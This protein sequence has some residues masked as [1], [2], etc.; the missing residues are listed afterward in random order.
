[1]DHIIGSRPPQALHQFGVLLLFEEGLWDT[2]RM[3]TVELYAAVRRAVFVE[4]LSQREATRR[5][6]LSRVT[7]AKMMRFSVP[8][9]YRRQQPPRRPKL[10]PYL[11]IIDQ[12][13]DQDVYASKKQRHTAWRLCERL[14][15]EYGYGGGYTIVK[16]YVRQKRV[17]GQWSAPKLCSNSFLSPVSIL[18]SRATPAQTRLAWRIPGWNVIFAYSSP[19]AKL[20]ASLS[21]APPKRKPHHPDIH[22]ATA[23]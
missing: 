20:P 22:R 2:Q 4:G 10:E 8:P 16:D 6:G 23:H 19:A 5:F 3:R 1:M 21:H 18:S 14:R 11:G 13:L 9:G 12:I 7:V 15:D 17:S